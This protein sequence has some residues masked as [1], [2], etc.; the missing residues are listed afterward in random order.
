MIS[1]ASAA[2]I[3]RISSG[4][5]SST[6]QAAEP[7]VP[8]TTVCPSH[9]AVPLSLSPSISSRNFRSALW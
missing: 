8:R 9:T 6:A 1:V 5:D 2:G 3:R 7:L 4:R